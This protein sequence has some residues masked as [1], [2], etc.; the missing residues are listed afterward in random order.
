MN[1]RKFHYKNYL[2]YIVGAKPI[3]NIIIFFVIFLLIIIVYL[4]DS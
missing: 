3:H 2:L 1:L 4:N